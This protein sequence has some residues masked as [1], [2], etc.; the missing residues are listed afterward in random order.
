MEYRP[1]AQ[2]ISKLRQRP[3]LLS[4]RLGIAMALM[5]YAMFFHT[6]E[7]IDLPLV[8][9]GFTAAALVAL[10]IGYLQVTQIRKQLD[11]IEDL[12]FGLTSDGVSVR[13]R[14]G[15]HQIPYPDIRT[16]TLFRGTSGESINRIQISRA[17]G[18]A[19]L[20]GLERTDEFVAELRQRL[21]QRAA[22]LEKRTFFG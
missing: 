11:G 21:G 12:R 15:Q 17:S 13:T 14:G 4:L 1:S 9:M 19:I 6:P 2:Y 22:I 10:C 5:G 20:P 8:L 7:G 18:Q 3:L 16:V